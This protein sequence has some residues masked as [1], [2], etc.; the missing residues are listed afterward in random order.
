MAKKRKTFAG[1]TAGEARKAASDWLRNFRDHGP[2]DIKSI[3]VSEENKFFV[4]TVLYAE[5]ELEPAPPQYFA[6]YQ[7]ALLKSA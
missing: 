2:L 3:S 6:H 5:M 4:A 1:Y 7:P